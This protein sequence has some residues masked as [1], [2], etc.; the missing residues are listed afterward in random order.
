MIAELLAGDLLQ[1][2]H[3]AHDLRLDFRV[4]GLAILIVLGAGFGRNSKALGDRQTDVG[5]FRQ[6]GALSAQKL[7]H[8]AVALGE[9]INVFVRHSQLP[10][11]MSMGVPFSPM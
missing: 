5:H 9:Q 11:S 1:L 8:F 2:V 7:P 6:I 3:I 4:D 10:L